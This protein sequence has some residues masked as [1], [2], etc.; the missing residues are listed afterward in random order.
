[1]DALGYVKNLE[2]LEPQVL[3]LAKIKLFC[4]GWLVNYTSY[5]LQPHLL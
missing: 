5:T 2:I 3:V 1:M 4:D